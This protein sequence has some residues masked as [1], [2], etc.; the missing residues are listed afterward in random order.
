MDKILVDKD[1][2]AL[3]EENAIL[4]YGMT[5][6][7]KELDELREKLGVKERVA[8][9]KNAIIKTYTIEEIQKKA[10]LLRM[11]VVDLPLQ[12]RTMNV[13]HGNNIRT[14]Y[15]IIKAGKNGILKMHN[16][17][18]KSKEDVWNFLAEVGLTWDINP[19]EILELDAARQL[20]K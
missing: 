2:E 19:D 1:Y 16:G 20:E 7:L 15:D 5:A 4:R 11:K 6:L 13:L 18:Q 8:Q 14:V 12:V 3:K 9:S 17:G 10:E